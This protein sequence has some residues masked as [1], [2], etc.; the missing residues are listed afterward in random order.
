MGSPYQPLDLA[1]DTDDKERE[2]LLKLVRIIF[3]ATVGEVPL[4]GVAA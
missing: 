1:P 2:L 4:E 3:D